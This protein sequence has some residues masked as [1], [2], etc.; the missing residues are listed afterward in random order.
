MAASLE[1]RPR[2]VSIYLTSESWFLRLSQQGGFANDA[3]DD[4]LKERKNGNFAAM[5][6]FRSSAQSFKQEPREQ[7]MSELL[8][9]PRRLICGR[10]SEYDP[11]IPR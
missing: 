7:S 5:Y 3:T 11:S 10:S 1:N 8:I 2:K 9:L 6:H 4:V